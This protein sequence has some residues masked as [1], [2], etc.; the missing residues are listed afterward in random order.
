[1]DEKGQILFL[2]KALRA[3]IAAFCRGGAGTWKEA[4]SDTVNDIRARRW[5][6]VFFGGTLRSLLWSRVRESAPGRPRD[7]DIVT[8]GAR[9]SDLEIAF[10]PYIVRNTRFGGLKLERVGSHAGLQKWEFDIWPLEETHAIKESGRRFPMFR[11]LPETTF[12][13]VESIA[14]DVWARRGTGRRIFSK[15]DQFFKGIINRTIEV[16]NWSNPFPELCVVR[17]LVMASQLEWKIGPKLLRFLGEYGLRMSQADFERIQEAHYGLVRLQGGA[18]KRA[19][20]GVADAIDRNE[21]NAVELVLPSRLALWPE[22]EDH[23][24]RLWITSVATAGKR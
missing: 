4:I 18:F 9:L 8:Q 12:F 5:Q 21:K 23:A 19:M 15:D 24:H 1:M 11:D 2:K 16:N 20:E 13:N 22:D 10:K 17:A 6:A 7:I 3:E 14:V